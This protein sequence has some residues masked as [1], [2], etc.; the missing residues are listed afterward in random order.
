MFLAYQRQE[1]IIQKIIK[2][3]KDI[4]MISIEEPFVGQS[5]SRIS[6]SILSAAQRDGC[7][8]TQQTELLPLHSPLIA[9]SFFTWRIG[10]GEIFSMLTHT[11]RNG[12]RLTN[13]RF[14]KSDEVD[15]ITSSQGKTI[16]LGLSIILTLRL[17]QVLDKLD[18]N[19][20]RDL[21][22]INYW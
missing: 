20:R 19:M 7:R 17:P 13:Y 22:Q 21:H 15:N 9:E 18:Q 10:R 12:R 14:S 4:C 6:P 16:G 2:A 5:L 11:Q 3:D 8:G 1:S